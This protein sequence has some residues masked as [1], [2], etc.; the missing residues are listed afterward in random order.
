M[1]EVVGYRVER[2]WSAVCDI[3][4]EPACEVVADDVTNI[5]N[6]CRLRK[7]RSDCFGYEFVL[8]G[9]FGEGNTDRVVACENR[10]YLG[11]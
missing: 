6:V 5:I 11:K 3:D 4:A 8:V 7:T 1:P 10:E 2:F 9:Y